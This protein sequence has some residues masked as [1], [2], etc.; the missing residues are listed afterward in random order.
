MDN[1]DRRQAKNK[2]MHEL[3]AWLSTML[4]G[5][6]PYRREGNFSED[7][8][9][10]HWATIGRKDGFEIIVNWEAIN[11]KGRIIVGC[12]VSSTWREV[13]DFYS[14]TSP[15]ITVTDESK[16]E[17]VLSQIKS[18]LLPDG[19]RWFEV[20]LQRYTKCKDYQ[21]RQ[22]QAL[23]RFKEVLNDNR[24]SVYNGE[25][26]GHCGS[27]FVVRP[28]EVGITVTLSHGEGYELGQLL[29]RFAAERLER[30]G[31]EDDG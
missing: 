15:K 28:E 9:P 22:A 27:R 20:Q 18:R 11:G 21:E 12:S 14:T 4:V 25:L 5:F 19:E 7:G 29:Q 13:R 26:Y 1:Y 16:P 17:R 10:H 23:K 24:S 2:E 31:A 6:Q 30:E 3:A 8:R